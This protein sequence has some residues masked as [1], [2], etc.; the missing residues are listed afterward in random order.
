MMKT[1]FLTRS[2]ALAG[3]LLLAVPLSAQRAAV[4]G[5]NG[6]VVSSQQMASQ[7]GVDILKKGGNAVDAAIATGLALAVVFPRAGNIG[8]GGFMVVHTAAGKDTVIDYRERA[9]KAA[10]QDMYLGPD[11]NVI[12]GE[13]G[14]VLGWK[15]SG[16]PGTVAGFYLAYQKYGSHTLKWADLVMPAAKLASDGFPLTP[17]LLTYPPGI[18]V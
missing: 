16:V 8:G 10:T 2:L 3:G 12:K 11:G 5:G 18:E 4:E 14:S 9:P 7:V 13:G 1:R 6:M 15:A 17:E